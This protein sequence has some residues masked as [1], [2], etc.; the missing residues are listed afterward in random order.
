MVRDALFFLVSKTIN[1]GG[2]PGKIDFET[3]AALEKLILKPPKTGALLTTKV[4]S[5]ALF[6]QVSKNDQ[7]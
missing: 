6:F 5:D 1:C 7:L 3:P 2:N 4:V